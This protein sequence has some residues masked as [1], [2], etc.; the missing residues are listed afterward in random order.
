M[1]KEGRKYWPYKSKVVSDGKVTVFTV[2]NQHYLGKDGAGKPKY[3]N[4]GWI[5][6]VAKINLPLEP[7]SGIAIKVEKIAGVEIKEYPEKSGKWQTTIYADVSL[8]GD[9]IPNYEHLMDDVPSGFTA[10]NDDE[11]P[12]E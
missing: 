12:F 6:I 4:A 7:K 11:I 9:N 5:D 8:V 2:G 1:I 10:V 3:K